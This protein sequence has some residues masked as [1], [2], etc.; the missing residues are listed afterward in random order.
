MPGGSSHTDKQW[1]Y[2]T[3]GQ[4][5]GPVPAS[6]LKSLYE[7]GQV[8]PDD[9]VWTPGM[10]DWR[11]ASVMA[12]RFLRAAEIPVPQPAPTRA[13]E[14]PIGQSE[15]R[16]GDYGDA[17]A[18]REEFGFGRKAVSMNYAG[19]FTRFVA[20]F[21]DGIILTAVQIPIAV[22]ASFMGGSAAPGPDGLPQVNGAV[23]LLNFIPI[24]IYWLYF[25]LQESGSYSATYGKRL[26][27]I[28]VTDVDG[29]PI[30]FGRATVRHFSKIIS[31]LVCCAGYL[32][33]PFTARKQ[34]LHDIIAGCVVIQ[35]RR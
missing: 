24:V 12:E 5:M 33:Q 20:A 13:V 28:F 25:A 9:L 14:A 18:F 31:S 10:E 7:S 1:Y 4:S 34:A 26:V 17:G 15:H 11:P 32:M 16:H 29:N 8:L 22:I 2:A 23:L 27:G 3:G 21:V 19:F 6:E 35:S 30:S